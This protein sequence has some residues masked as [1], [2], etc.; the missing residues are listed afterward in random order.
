MLASFLP[1]SVKHLTASAS[2]NLVKRLERRAISTPLSQQPV[3]TAHVQQGAG[4]TPIL[5]L[6]GFDSSVLEFRHL[7]PC[8]A[9]Q[10]ETWAVDLLGFGFTDRIKGIAFDPP[11]IK[12]HLYCFWKTLIDQPVILVGASMGG[13]AA[14]DFTLTHPEV[15]E[16]LVLIGSVGYT[17]S[18]A[19]TQFLFPPLNY[20]AVEYLRQR[21]L[22]ALEICTALNASPELLELLRCAAL[23][24]EMPSWHEATIA[25]THS[26]GYNFLTN[27]IGQINQPTLILWGESDEILGTDDAKKFQRDIAHS[28]LVWIKACGHAPQLEQP[29]LTAQRIL[30]FRHQLTHHYP[31]PS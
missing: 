7:L 26:G 29:Q 12:T 21:K 31:N 20:L 18:P 14:I 13:A 2:I 25:F 30:E 22:K 10:N 24:Q 3:A 15:V 17:C 28:Q 23:H 9:T 5:L 4:G 19:F 8:L 6:H 1:D 27:R 11:A 16:K